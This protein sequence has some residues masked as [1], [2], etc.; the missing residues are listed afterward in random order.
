MMR[1]PPPAL[2][3]TAALAQRALTR[4]AQ[5]PTAARAATASATAAVSIALA[6]GAARQFRRQGTTVDPFDP[7][8]ASALVTTGANAVSRNPMY[9]GMAGLLVANA[10]RRGSWTALLPVVGFTLL[11]DRVQIAAEEAALLARFGAD[12][13]A[14]RTAAPRWLGRRSLAL[15]AEVRDRPPS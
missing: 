4:D 5:P 9:V 3:I 1:P 15:A 13:E 2:A 7:A 12:Y 8:R 10:V 6:A 14:Y 11:I